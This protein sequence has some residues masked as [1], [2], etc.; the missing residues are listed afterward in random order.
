VNFAR[1]EQPMQQYELPQPASAAIGRTDLRLHLHTI[2]FSHY[3][4][5][6]RLA[7]T[8]CGLKY[9][10]HGALPFR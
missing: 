1:A 9:T 6:A 2:S 7:L 10:E 5:K 3:N 8:L 4:A